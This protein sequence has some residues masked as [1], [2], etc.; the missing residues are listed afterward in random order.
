[1]TKTNHRIS[2]RLAASAILSRNE[3]DTD[4]DVTNWSAVYV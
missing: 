2:W 4:G 1:M 3:H